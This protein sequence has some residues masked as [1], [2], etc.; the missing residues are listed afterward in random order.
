MLKSR[1]EES[2]PWRPLEVMNG[3]R[4]NNEMEPSFLRSCFPNLTSP[5]RFLLQ[6]AS[7][8][9]LAVGIREIRREA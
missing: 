4:G 7:D 6:L 5:A 2:L 8:T 1:G 9:K 3:K